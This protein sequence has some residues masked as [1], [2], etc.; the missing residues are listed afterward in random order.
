MSYSRWSYSKWYSFWNC[1]HDGDIKENQTMSLWKAKGKILDW[2][3]SDLEE[4]CVRD[5][6]TIYECSL[7]EAEEAM[8]YIKEFIDDVNDVFDNRK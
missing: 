1:S 7:E 8:L 6:Q 3:Y 4:M 2:S 5:V